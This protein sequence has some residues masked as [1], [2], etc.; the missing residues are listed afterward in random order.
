MPVPSRKKI[1]IADDDLVVLK[2]LS[3]KLSSIGYE[4]VKV[5]DSGLVTRRIAEETPNLIM[6]DLDFGATAV[7][8]HVEWDGLKMLD[9]LMRLEDL[10]RI[11]VIVITASTAPD[12]D[13]ICRSAGA[14]AV[15]RK[16]IDFDQLNAEITRLTGGA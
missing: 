8:G 12:L 15:F 14:T 13:K 1:L 11:P 5:F 16:P 9:W 2:V 10:A 4:V 7:Y 3:L 6:L